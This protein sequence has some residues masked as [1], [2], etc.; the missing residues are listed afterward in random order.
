MHARL[1]ALSRDLDLLVQGATGFSEL[2]QAKNREDQRFKCMI[3]A[4]KPH[5]IPFTGSQADMQARKI[6]EKTGGGGSKTAREEV[7]ALV[8]DLD[9]LLD[10]IEE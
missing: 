8:M 3:R 6:W 7:D 2:V 5:F 9:D 1:A 10:H 4:T